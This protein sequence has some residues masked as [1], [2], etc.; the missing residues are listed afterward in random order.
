MERLVL[1]P[2]SRPDR[3]PGPVSN[4]IDVLSQR[5]TTRT[6]AGTWLHLLSDPDALLTSCV[7][8]VNGSESKCLVASHSI[9]PS[10]LRS[11]LIRVKRL[12]LK[13]RHF[14]FKAHELHVVTTSSPSK[15]QGAG[16]T[17]FLHP[18][19]PSSLPLSFARHPQG[20]KETRDEATP[21][22]R[23]HEERAIIDHLINLN[24]SFWPYKNHLSRLP[25]LT[26][27]SVRR[28]QHVQSRSSTP[29]QDVRAGHWQGETSHRFNSSHVLPRHA[30]HP[31][32][33]NLE[34]LTGRLDRRREGKASRPQ[35]LCQ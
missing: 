4:K 35:S 19:N 11:A 25:R 21:Y 14:R 18:R 8:Q 28:T 22:C 34:P 15:S 26:H 20:S 9:V 10:G 31:C 17:M 23:V 24:Y 32:L 29:S 27:I 2:M 33:V 30:D 12:A 3:R 6:S 7:S 13:C 1:E 16:S 5:L